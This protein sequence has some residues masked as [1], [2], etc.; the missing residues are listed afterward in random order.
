MS[1]VG[2]DPAEATSQPAATLLELRHGTRPFELEQTP[3]LIGRIPP[4]QVELPLTQVSRRHAWL[5]CDAEGHWQ[6]SDLQSASGTL[7]NGRRLLPQ[8]WYTLAPGDRLH[9]ADQQVD[10]VSVRCSVRTPPPRA[11]DD[12]LFQNVVGRETGAALGRLHTYR[13]RP[14][15]ALGGTD[16]SQALELVLELSRELAR[17]QELAPVLKAVQHAV[18]RLVGSAERLVLVSAR[19]DAMVHAALERGQVGEVRPEWMSQ[20]VVDWVLASGSVLISNNPLEDARFD[21]AQSLVLGRARGLLVAPISDGE[22]VVGVLYVDTA[23]SISYPAASQRIAD[24]V[25][26]IAEATLGAV[27]R[28]L[29]TRAHRAELAMRQNLQ[30]FLAPQVVA[31][32]RSEG[33]GGRRLAP[34]KVEASVLF[35]DIAGFTDLAA[36]LSPEDI[37]DVLNLVFDALVPVVFAHEG[38]LDKFIGDCVMAVFGA[39]DPMPDH[40]DRAVAAGL[41]LLATFERRIAPLQLPSPVKLRVAVHSGPLVAAEMGSE[42]RR[43]YTV[44]GSTV[45]IAARIEGVGEAGALTVSAQTLDLL[46]RPWLAAEVGQFLL[47][48]VPTP[49]RLF[50]LARD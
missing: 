8:Q 29:Q 2:P 11:P 24:I 12:P 33:Q 38:T 14:V 42:Q 43:E 44:I 5:R 41:D 7:L 10:V 39:P 28:L 32:L 4:A 46:R 6:V 34:R 20:T 30:R 47:K 31:R 37:A 48:G 27:D 35:A 1:A 17:A 15:L 49:T 16:A 13:V 50:R 23:A 18:A 9:I 26:A 25:S 45:N 40:A 21:G 3:A 19:A 22:R 36:R